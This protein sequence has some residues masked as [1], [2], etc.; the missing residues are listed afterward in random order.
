MADF[1]SGF[2]AQNAFNQQ[3]TGADVSNATG[4]LTLVEHLKQMQQAQQLRDALASGDAGA[5][6]RAPGGLAALL[7]QAQLKEHLAK[8]AAAERETAFFSPEN[9]AQ[10]MTPGTPAVAAQAP[11]TPNDDEG[12]ANTGVVAQPATPGQFNLRAFAESGAGQGIKGAEPLLNHL[13]QRDQ[14]RATME[15]NATLR[16][17]ALQQQ[18]ELARQRSEDM[19]FSL[20]ERNQ[21][22]MDYARLAASLRP[23]PQEPLVPVKGPDGT[24]IYAPRSQATGMEVGARTTDQNLSKQVQQLGTAFEKAGLPQAIGVVNQA[25]KITPE[26][27]EYLTGWKGMIP[28]PAVSQDVRD[29]RQDLAK[30]FNITL[31]DR[32]GAAV[33]NQEL[34]RLKEEFGKG[35]LR[36]PQSLINA[37]GKARSIIEQHYQGIAAGYGKNVVDAY[38]ENLQS[39]GGAPLEFRGSA[40]TGP[41]SGYADPAKEQR[42]QAWKSKNGG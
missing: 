31:K 11:V 40:P 25:G 29:A 36:Q 13:A 33:T 23:Q 7:Q 8:G 26:L 16:R 32:S 15:Q 1:L 42:Y 30:L 18:A 12:N 22:R 3:R 14:V 21:A 34:Q 19:R 17:E 38:N 41:A 35:L 10:F 5:L 9:R 2:N 6:A 39:M 20:S 4:A 24:V 28:D 37:V 27:A